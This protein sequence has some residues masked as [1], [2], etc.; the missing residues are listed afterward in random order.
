MFPGPTWR[1]LLPLV[2]DFVVPVPDDQ[3]AFGCVL[4]IDHTKDRRM[5]DNLHGGCP[6]AGRNAESRGLLHRHHAGWHCDPTKPPILDVASL[7]LAS[8]AAARAVQ[9]ERRRV[10]SLRGPPL[11]LDASQQPPSLG[12]RSS[13]SRDVAKASGPAEVHQLNVRLQP[14]ARVSSSC[15]ASPIPALRAEAGPAV[16]S[17][18]PHSPKL[19]P[20]DE[21]LLP[22]RCLSLRRL[23]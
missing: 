5:S 23:P 12:Q 14:S 15:N 7:G 11:S 17:C 21:L 13:R 9:P 18:R 16:M 4:P 20:R 8:P 6:I 3:P 19:T 22:G 10:L 2:S 1:T